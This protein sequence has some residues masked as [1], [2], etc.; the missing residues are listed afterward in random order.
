MCY[1]YHMNINT[2][3]VEKDN[4]PI[5]PHDQLFKELIE[6]FFKDFMVLFCSDVAKNIDFRG[7][8]FL[9]QE[10]FSS[11]APKE[12]EKRLDIVAEVRLQGE[13]RHILI[14]VEHQSQRKTDF[15]ERMFNYF[16]HLWLTHGKD[17]LP[18]A[19][20]SDDAKWNKPIPDH[21]E[22]E[23]SGKTV[24]AFK[25]E[26]I[27]LKNFNWRDYLETENPIAVALMSKM[28]Y[29]KEEMLSVKTEISRILFTGKLRNHPKTAII[30]NFVEYY[31]PLNTK[32]AIIYKEELKKFGIKERD[33]EMILSKPYQEKYDAGVFAGTTD[34][35]FK[36]IKNLLE[37][38]SDW[39]FIKKI[40][41]V[42]KAQYGKLKKK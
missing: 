9:Q 20:F 11:K 18:I 28:G 12:G 35:Q 31:L 42:T 29:K 19:I 1:L 4:K 8:K 41:G 23:V 30:N 17:I 6:T 27:K 5:N 32:E 38:G 3:K 36:V 7:V 37:E 10:V 21:F 25:Y 34:N 33:L 2:D 40:T 26:L 15:P 24:L 14:H 13:L 16:C 39:S 22:I